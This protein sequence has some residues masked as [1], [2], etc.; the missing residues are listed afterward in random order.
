MDFLLNTSIQAQFDPFKV[1]FERLCSGPVMPMFQPAELELV[2]CGSQD[3]DFE[4][5]QRAAQYDGGFTKESPEIGWFW[6][7]VHGFDEAQ[8]K[9]LLL[10]VTSSERVPINGL[11]ALSPPFCISKN[12]PHSDRL[13]T[14]HTCFN[15]LLLPQYNSKEHLQDRLEVALENAQ[16]FGLM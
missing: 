14:A 7:V 10:F 13:P 6:N 1:G 5:L 3:L 4:D 11:S 16:G 12:G 15:I 9:K 2:I 8:K